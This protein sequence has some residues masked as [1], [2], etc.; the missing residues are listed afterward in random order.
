[1]TIYSVFKTLYTLDDIF[2]VSL[3]SISHGDIKPGNILLSIDIVSWR[4]KLILTDFGTSGPDEKPSDT[5]KKSSIYS[6]T[7]KYM[8]YNRWGDGPDQ[9]STT[10]GSYKSVSY[11][12]IIKNSTASYDKSLR[13]REHGN[14][15][16]VY[17]IGVTLLELIMS[18]SIE[19][20]YCEVGIAR[21]YELY[22]VLER[23]NF[24]YGYYYSR[25]PK[26]LELLQ[27]C[28]QKEPSDRDSFYR[29]FR[30]SKYFKELESNIKTLET[31]LLEFLNLLVYETTSV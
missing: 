13:P 16:D 22:H 24:R 21:N 19:Y 11:E 20:F 8:P 15:D 4:C 5:K 2:K 25:C 28:L 23:D 3:G 26:L 29:N 12:S 6:G 27:N 31:N 1:M 30:T 7:Q 10:T 18:T 17:A 9:Q 14:A